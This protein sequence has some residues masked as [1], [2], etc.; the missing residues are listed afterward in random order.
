MLV[1]FWVS[2]ILSHDLIIFLHCSHSKRLLELLEDIESIN[3]LL[4][5]PDTLHLLFL[6]PFVQISSADFLF[7]FSSQAADYLRLHVLRK[8]A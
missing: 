1:G 4:A 8:Q 2:A 7:L 3:T 5:F 6:G